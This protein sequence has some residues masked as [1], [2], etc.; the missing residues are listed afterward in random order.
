MAGA[1]QEIVGVHPHPTST[2]AIRYAM[3]DS[4]Q[5]QPMITAPATEDAKTWD[6]WGTA[7]KPAFEPIV[8]AR[9]PIKGTVAA[10]VLQWGTGAINIDDCRVPLTDDDYENS[11]RRGFAGSKN[12]GTAFFH[13]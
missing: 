5:E 4:W 2:T 11:G 8:L 1:E 13:F 6:G 3:R 12:N 9:K 10:N 7:L